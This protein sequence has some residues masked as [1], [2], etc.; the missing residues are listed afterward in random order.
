MIP[1]RNTRHLKSTPNTLGKKEP[2]M[3]G[4]PKATKQMQ[5]HCLRKKNYATDW[6]S[7]FT[8][9]SS[10]TSREFAELSNTPRHKQKYFYRISFSRINLKSWKQRTAH[11]GVLNKQGDLINQK[12]KWGEY[13]CS[14]L[15]IFIIQLFLLQ[16]KIFIVFHNTP[17]K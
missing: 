11:Y 2:L 6:D 7:L 15:A 5:I 13:F 1:S 9:F 3:C 4:Y 14:I 8:N 12:R 10:L 16:L 17:G